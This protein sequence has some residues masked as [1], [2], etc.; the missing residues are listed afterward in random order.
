MSRTCSLERL[1]VVGNGMAGLRLVEELLARS[2]DRFAVTVVGKEPEPT[3]NRVLLSA[4]LAGDLTRE[5]ANLRPVSWYEGQCVTLVTGDPVASIDAAARSATLASGRN[6]EWD[7]LVFATGSEAVRLP[8]PGID[9]PSVATFRDFVDL[10]V[11]ERLDPGQSAVVIG[12]GLL[13]LE[14]AFG[15]SKRGVNVTLIHLMDRL[16]ERQLN[17]SAANLLRDAVEARGIT[18]VLEATTAAIEGSEHAEAVRL[19]DGKV[20]P[21]DLVVCAVGIRPETT[22]AAAAGVACERGIQVDDTL[23]TSADGVYAIDECAEHNGSCYGLVERAYEQAKVLADH[24]A[25]NDQAR[26]TGSVV[27]TNLK[28]SGVNVFSAGD[29]L[30]DEG[31][32]AI[33]FRD[34]GVPS[35]RKLVLRRDGGSESARL[36]GAVLFGDVAGSLWYLELIRT[37]MPVD[38]LRPDL[39]FGRAFVDEAA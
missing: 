13:G 3:Y 34:P 18:V 2:P 24:L 6:L 29:F 27:A 33:V 5:D 31:C 15:L 17:S 12:G 9:L 35:Y 14:A 4:I 38:H 37:R 20:I 8:L 32:E 22:L 21:A 25:G 23:A 16:M 28:V 1:L 19:T 10:N 30:D 39:I 36:V 11:F 26:Y 7:R